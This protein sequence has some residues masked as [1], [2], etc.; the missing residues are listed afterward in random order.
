[1][2]SIVLGAETAEAD[3]L[4]GL[5]GVQ[6]GE[7]PRARDLALQFRRL[8]A[9]VVIGGFHV[10]SD[11][12]SR[13][14][15]ESAGVT[16]VTGEA[17]GSM[18]RLLDDFLAG[19]MRPSYAVEDGMYART[20]LGTISVPAL[21]GAAFPAIEPRYLQRFFNPRF[22]TIDTSRGCPFVCSFCA[23]KN[24][25][26]RSVRAREPERVVDWVRLAHDDHGVHSFLLVDDDLFRSPAWEPLLAGLA[27]LRRAG[28]SISLFIQ[29]DVEAAGAT[30]ICEDK[31]SS[32]RGRRF[33]EMAAE[34]GCYQVFMGFESL[35][36]ANLL[37][38]RK[39]QN[40]ANPG[41][42][43]AQT[44][45]ER[46][47]RVV[48]AW[49]AAGVG[50]HCGYMLGLPGDR[51]GCGARAAQELADIGVDIVSFFAATPLPG[52]EDYHAAL[53]DGSLLE[54]D[55]NA[56]DTTHFIRRH[57]ILSR[58]ELAREYA[59]AYRTFY[60]GRRLLWSLATLHR[61]PDLGWSAR[62]GMLTQQLYYGYATR[63]GWHP[64]LGGIGRRHTRERRHAI[65]DEQARAT[66]L[67]GLPPI[68]L[69]SDR[70]SVG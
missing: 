56:Y 19:R 41:R 52:T 36:A 9:A 25:M 59:D 49:H 45:H 48:A 17:E 46:Y 58:E 70:V 44:L 47:R 33:R 38:M 12:A 14:F 50:V 16:T 22:S 3:L 29:T 54:T 66:Y 42:G 28:R 1:M 69:R 61:V 51:A 64:M 60:S 20:G 35:D 2:A 43:G 67:G 27:G 10:S 63:S 31:P 4:I 30:E 26:G 15:L 55:W 68:L 53:A 8:G 24:I 23:V 6:T 7:Y 11:P 62:L 65:G 37:A 5:A 57:P 34:A 21:A 39:H 32:R 13:R 18:A 40:Q